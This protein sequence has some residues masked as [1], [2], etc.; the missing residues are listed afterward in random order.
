MAKRVLTCIPKWQRSMPVFAALARTLRQS[1]SAA[2]SP[3]DIE[4]MLSQPSWSV[5]SLLKLD[6]KDFPTP[7]LTQAQLHHLLRLSALPIPNSK[8]EEAKMVKDLQSQLKFVQA[9]QEVD[10]K[11]VE[12]L[13][14]IRDETKAAEMENTITVDT[15]QA[16]FEK[17]EVVGRRGRIRRKKPEMDD[18]EKNAHS[19]ENGASTVS[20]TKQWDPLRQAPK[21]QGRYFVVDTAND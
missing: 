13:E 20:A 8:D 14:A 5:K 18:V 2:K 1:S 19:D 6:A 16:E 17:E 7:S 11:G 21:K 10:T 4:A 3:N 12:P 9:I 15:L